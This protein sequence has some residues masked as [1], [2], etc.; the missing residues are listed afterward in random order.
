MPDLCHDLRTFGGNLVSLGVIEVST[1]SSALAEGV[2]SMP[3]FCHDLKILGFSVVNL[4][5]KVP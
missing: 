1:L 5:C 3:E 4:Y 2:V